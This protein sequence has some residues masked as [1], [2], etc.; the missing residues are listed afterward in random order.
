MKR[1]AITL[2]TP[3]PQSIDVHPRRHRDFDPEADTTP[4]GIGQ[5]PQ[6]LPSCR[7]WVC[8][9][10][11]FALNFIGVQKLGVGILNRQELTC[12]RRLPGSVRSRYEY[13]VERHLPFSQSRYSSAQQWD[14]LRT[15]SSIT[16]RRSSAPSRCWAGPVFELLYLKHIASVVGR[17]RITH[18]A[19]LRK[20][21]TFKVLL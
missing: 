6:E 21:S 1:D 8:E 15:A 17:S 10:D 3:P 13:R 5:A 11:T 4:F 16:A 19:P 7:D 2:L 18:E 20:S 12:E 14:Q 9:R